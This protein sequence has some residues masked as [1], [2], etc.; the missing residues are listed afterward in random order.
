MSSTNLFTLLLDLG[1]QL[2]KLQVL[3]LKEA[4]DPFT[5]WN[6]KLR[7]S[8]SLPSIAVP[9]HLLLFVL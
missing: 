5:A 8:V 7:M 9:A 1:I 3:G 4:D 6:D 2:I